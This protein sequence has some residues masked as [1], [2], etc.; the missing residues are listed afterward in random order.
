MEFENKIKELMELIVQTLERRLSDESLPENTFYLNN[1]D[2]LCCPRKNGESRYPYVSDGLTLW[3]YSNG[4]VQIT[5][6]VFNVFRP[7][8]TENESPVNFADV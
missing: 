7:V 6:G 2:I 8:H 1:G 3:A 4:T 5:E